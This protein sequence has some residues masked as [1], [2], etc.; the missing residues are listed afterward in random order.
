MGDV[1]GILD[2]GGDLGGLNQAS[3]PR[4]D[5]ALRTLIELAN[6][7]M[8]AAA[9]LERIKDA[10]T[11][12]DLITLFTPEAMQHKI[13]GSK[14]APATMRSASFAPASASFQDVQHATQSRVTTAMTAIATKVA[15]TLFTQDAPALLRAMSEQRHFRDFV[16]PQSADDDESGYAEFAR[17]KAVLAIGNQLNGLYSLL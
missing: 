1:E 16:L 12:L 4:R 9:E 6:T 10:P 15:E 13:F 7:G 3:Q 2:G 5:A 8:S 11:A 17:N 14:G